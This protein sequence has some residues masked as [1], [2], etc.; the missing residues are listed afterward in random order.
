M[1]AKLSSPFHGDVK[2]APGPHSGAP[3]EYNK[4][5]YPAVVDKPRDPGVLDELFYAKGPALDGSPAK[6]ASHF[7]TAIPNVGKGFKGSR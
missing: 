4:N 5:C 3:G 7:G 1:P 6:L 2:P